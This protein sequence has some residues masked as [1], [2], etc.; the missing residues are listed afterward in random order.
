[1]TKPVGPIC[2]LDCKYCFYLEKEKLYP[3]NDGT[4]ARWAM[5]E[6]VLESYI[7]QHIE[8]QQA[9]TILFAWQGG[10]PTLLGVDYYRRI[11]EL[12]RKYA[13]GKRIENTLQTNGVLLDDEWCDFLAAN[14]WLVGLSID[15]PRRFHDR[16]RVDKG[17]APTFDKV[18]RGL[19][20]LKQHGVEFNTLTVVQ[21]DNS[22][23]PLEIYRFL[24]QMG[25]GYMQ[26]IPVVERTGDPAESVAEWSVDPLQYGK[27]LCA[28][29]DEWVRHDV[30]RYYVQIFDVSLESWMGR[31]PSLCVFRETCGEGLALEHNG[32]LYSCDHFVYPKYKLGNLMEQSLGDM[33]RGAQQEQ[34]GLDKRDTLPKYCR[35]CDVRFACNGECPKHRFTQTPEGEDGLNY[36]CPSYKLF[37]HHI[38]APMRFMAGEL[39]AG[40]APANV[41]QWIRGEAGPAGRNDIC[42]CGSG[43]K[44]KRCCGR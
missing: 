18:M 9:P 2:N 43:R 30:G 35:E 41:M 37:F 27:F 13:G 38:D 14:K 40:R 16:Y 15:G 20:L 25:S 5:S 22:Q 10:E 26:F 17:G 42:P 33:V 6:A 28:I 36:L 3:D 24:K 7:R 23:S 44:F 34:F 12:Q 19:K 31:T 4:P 21:R 11:E 39:R 8:S 1:M 32:D 29:F